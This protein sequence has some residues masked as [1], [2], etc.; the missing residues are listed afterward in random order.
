MDFGPDRKRRWKDIWGAGQGI[1]AVEAVLPA[2]SLVA[3]LRAEYQAARARL[4]VRS[5]L[6]N[7]AWEA[8]AAVAAAAG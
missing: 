1:G 3:R 7:S 2:A 8:V 4:G 6:T 5:P